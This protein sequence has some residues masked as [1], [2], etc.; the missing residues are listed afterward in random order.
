MATSKRLSNDVDYKSVMD[1][2]DKLM[3]KGS[4]NLPKAQLAEIRK[5]ALQVQDYEQKKFKIVAPGT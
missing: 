5:M 3:S 4:E 1:K 2:I